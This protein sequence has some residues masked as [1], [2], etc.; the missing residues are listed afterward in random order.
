VVGASVARLAQEAWAETVA[1][2]L[3]GARQLVA[4]A[5]QFVRGD[6]QLVRFLERGIQPLSDL[7]GYHGTPLMLLRSFRDSQL[8]S[9]ARCTTETRR[10]QRGG[11]AVSF[12]AA[13]WLGAHR[14]G[15]K[16]IRA[17]SP[18][19]DISVSSVSPW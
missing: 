2:E 10:T 9:K 3:L 18:Q 14:Q 15:A 8:F 4:E 19:P 17:A 5:A 1:A 6:L 11:V 16:R 7:P 13:W 12:L